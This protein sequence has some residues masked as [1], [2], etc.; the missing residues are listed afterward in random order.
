MGS[1]YPTAT[2]TQPA[3][4]SSTSANHLT[5]IHIHIHIG[6]GSKFIPSLCALEIVASPRPPS[7][8]S[9]VQTMLGEDSAHRSHHAA[10]ALIAHDQPTPVLTFIN[11]E[12]RA[13]KFCLLS[14]RTMRTP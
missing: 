7:R 5:L 3:V 6:R 4:L 8:A 11:A 12:R 2:A 1:L 13:P 14:T 10:S 9:M